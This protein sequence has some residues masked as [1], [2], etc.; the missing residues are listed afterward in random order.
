MLVSPLVGT[1]LHA[2]SRQE[3]HLLTTNNLQL[4]SKFSLILGQIS[5]TEVL[6]KVLTK[7]T[8]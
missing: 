5:T 6:F 3:A 1:R 8:I 2:C 7:V 4:V